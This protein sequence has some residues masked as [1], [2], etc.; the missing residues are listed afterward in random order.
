LE[1]PLAVVTVTVAVE[2]GTMR[3]SP[4]G[5]DGD[6]MVNVI[7]LSLQLFQAEG[8]RSGGAPQFVP[9]SLNVM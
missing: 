6:G 7:S 9:S 2:P 1:V 8:A 5:P 3:H 4:P